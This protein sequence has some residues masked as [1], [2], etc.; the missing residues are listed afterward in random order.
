M[1]DP[2]YRVRQLLRAAN[3]QPL[4]RQEIERVQTV[5]TPDALALYQTMPLGD[6]HHSLVILD[7]LRAQGYNDRPLLQAALLHDVAKRKI[8]LGHRTGVVVLN[9]WSADALARWASDD[10]NSW[11]YPFYVSLHHP[12]LG[13]EMAARVG[14]D[15]DA[16]ELI[17]VHQVAA[18]TFSG[19]DAARLEQWHHALKA[20][21]DVN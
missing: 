14:I 17:R 4:S 2:L 6:Q 18:P 10:T 21:D 7:A 8:G 13:A 12:E 1:N 20:L 3:A 15:P 11:R 19:A 9:K 16:V 5:L